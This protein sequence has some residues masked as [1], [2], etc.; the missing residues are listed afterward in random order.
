MQ[1][2]D[3]LP[4]VLVADASPFGI[5]A[6]LGDALPDGTE[7][8]I[9]CY[10]RTLSS[11]ERNYGQID[12]EVLAAV[13]AI[14]R[15]HDYLYGHPFTLVTD[16][17]PFL[18]LLAGNIQTPQVLSPRMSRWVEFLAAYSYT[19][20]YR[21]GKHL[22]HA[23]A[24]SCCPMPISVYDPSPATQVLLIDSLPVPITASD[25]ATHSA[26]DLTICR[27]LDWVRR[28]WPPGQVGPEFR[29]YTM[30]DS[31]SCLYSEGVCYGET[32]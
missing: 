19:L 28:G 14:K 15:F 29:A 6:V 25:V 2:T 5:G 20:V 16:H 1:Y 12:K 11:T 30:S 18:G 27:V 7:A 4:L 21:P 31:T 10:S 32:E 23:D 8:P 22:A 13:A 17:K 26:K 9:A 24:L 3:S